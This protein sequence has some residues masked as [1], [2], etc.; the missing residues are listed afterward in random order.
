MF[1][2]VR[3]TGPGIQPDERERI[4]VPFISRDNHGTGLGLPIGRELAVALGGRLELEST[5]GEGSRFR[6]VLPERPA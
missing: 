1:I 5:V 3:D 6:L 4:F 2:D